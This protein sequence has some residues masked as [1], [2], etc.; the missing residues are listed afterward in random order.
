MVYRPSQARGPKPLRSRER[1]LDTSLAFTQS[2][3]QLLKVHNAFFEFTCEVFRQGASSRAKTV[4]GLENPVDRGGEFAS[5][6][7]T[8]EADELR[9]RYSARDYVFH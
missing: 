7:A 9:A 8:A 3:K 5:M 6:F 1:P 2:D 4:Y